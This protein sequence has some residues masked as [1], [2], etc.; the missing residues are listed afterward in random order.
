MAATY[1]YVAMDRRGER[2]RGVSRA[3]NESDVV[4]EVTASGLTPISVRK[5]R[6][7][8]AGSR[9]VRT[10]D[11]AQFTYQLGV[12]INAR[13]PIG[14]GLRSIAEQEGPGKFRDMLLQMAIRIE[15][16]DRIADAMKE[17]EKV[18]GKVVIET[19]SA[20]RR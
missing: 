10:K 1:E 8:R 15:S 4:R 19:V 2:V 16:G 12:L 14:D 13:I 11:I 5:A 7:K 18:L 17:H 6:I 3:Q 20:S 9:R